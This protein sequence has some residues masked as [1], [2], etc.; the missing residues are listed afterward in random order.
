[1]ARD[2]TTRQAAALLG[3][4]PST[5][6]TLVWHEA[7]RQVLRAAEADLGAETPPGRGGPGPG[8]TP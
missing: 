7:A 4:S 6:R 8:G 1:M 5:L 2:L 3:V